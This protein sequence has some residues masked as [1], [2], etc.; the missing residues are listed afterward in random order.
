MSG[1]RGM[2][3]VMV[4]MFGAVAAANADTGKITWHASADYEQHA[5]DAARLGA[6]QTAP[7]KA[8]MIDGG[9]CSCSKNASGRVDCYV[10]ITWETPPKR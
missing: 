2:F 5:C 8:K 4:L 3:L 6:L 9:Q 1:K 7:D 10:T